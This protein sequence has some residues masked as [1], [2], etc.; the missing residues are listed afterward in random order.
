[1]G[2]IVHR[3]VVVIFSSLWLGNTNRPIHT[4][5][6]VACEMNLCPSEPLKITNGF[7]TFYIPPTGSKEGW[8]RAEQQTQDIQRFLEYLDTNLGLD[9]GAN[10]AYVT[11]GDTESKLLVG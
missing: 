9:W 4:P 2:T 8:G 6:E 11:F 3:S 5:H 7:L 10:W 1:M